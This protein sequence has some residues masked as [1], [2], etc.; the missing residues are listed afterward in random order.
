MKIICSWKDYYD[1]VGQKFGQDPNVAYERKMLTGSYLIPPQ[2]SRGAGGQRPIF[3]CGWFEPS[4]NSGLI[5]NGVFSDLRINLSYVVVALKAYLVLDFATPDYYRRVFKTEIYDPE[6]HNRFFST[7]YKDD[8]PYLPEPPTEESIKFAIKTIGAPIFWTNGREENWGKREATL[9]VREKVP[10]L[11][12]L[13]FPAILPPEQ[14]WQEIYSVM[15]NVLRKN[16]D[17]EPPLTIGNED[18]IEAA[19]FDLKTSFRNPI[20]FKDEK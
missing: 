4:R 19:G 6:K 7:H 11:K 18:R 1:F 10:C 12:D 16:P 2:T 5:N 8:S 15:Q 3:G 20:K 13:G 17:K 14:A 9:L